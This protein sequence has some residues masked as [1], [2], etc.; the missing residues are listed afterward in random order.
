MADRDD[1]IVVRTARTR[2]AGWNLVRDYEVESGDRGRQRREVVH[3]PDLAAVLPYSPQRRTA[4]LVSQIRLAGHLA[5]HGGP[6]LEA[7]SGRIEPGEAPGAAAMRELREETGLDV[8][9]LAPVA[10]V[11]LHPALST[12]RAHLFLCDLDSAFVRRTPADTH[13]MLGDVR[14][15][16]LPLR[17]IAF[18]EG[19][20]VDA[21][22]ALLV[23]LLAV[24]RP[25]LFA[26]MDA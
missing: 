20:L 21:K 23:A 10:C 24:R 25:E 13:D 12:E 4:T 18:G 6:L 5:G 2:Y 22:T 8:S 9:V 14:V 15:E 19:G 11:F 16:E 7:P 26:E 3:R 17:A 1:D